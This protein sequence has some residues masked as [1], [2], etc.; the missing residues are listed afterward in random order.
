MAVHQEIWVIWCEIAIWRMYW[1]RCIVVGLVDKDPLLGLQS[2]DWIVQH[3]FWYLPECK[4]NK[5]A[6]QFRPQLKEKTT[7]R[8]NNLFPYNDS[9]QIEKLEKKK[10]WLDGVC[11]SY[12]NSCHAYMHTAACFATMCAPLF[13]SFVW[14]LRCT[15]A[16]F[17]SA[18][19]LPPID[20]WEKGRASRIGSRTHRRWLVSP[21]HRWAWKEALPEPSQGHQRLPY[22]FSIG[23][24]CLEKT[25]HTAGD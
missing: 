4:D 11:M 2:E 17:T 16:V 6:G 7:E 15:I 22:R 24:Y 14:C 12:S 13:P 19:P 25:P 20:E 21:G 10:K 9:F 5:K 3:Q 1:H 8:I 23:L 18:S